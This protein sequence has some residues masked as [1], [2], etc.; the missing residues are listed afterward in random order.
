MKRFLSLVLSA[1]FVF[2]LGNASCD[3]ASHYRSSVQNY[4]MGVTPQGQPMVIMQ[5]S[6]YI[7]QQQ[8][9]INVT[10]TEPTPQNITIQQ[11]EM[12]PNFNVKVDATTFADKLWS[13]LKIALAAAAICVTANMCWPVIKFVTGISNPLDTVKGW[14]ESAVK[15]VK[16]IW[17]DNSEN[18]ISSEPAGNASLWK[19]WIIPIITLGMM[20][21]SGVGNTPQNNKRF[22]HL[23][24]KPFLLA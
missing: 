5:A 11:P 10:A 19:K 17:N 7:P 21:G 3:A 24:F 12:K 14:G 18:V 1:L 13:W 6:P 2:Q 20:R 8:P 16:G 4:N 15:W 22:E 23:S 9:I